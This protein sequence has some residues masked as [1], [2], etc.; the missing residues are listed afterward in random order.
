MKTIIM[1]KLDLAMD[2]GTIVE[3]FKREGEEVKEGERVVSIMTQKVTYEI[4]SPA[5]GTLYKVFASANEDVPVGKPIA[6]IME[7]GD[8]VADV[9]RYIRE[10]MAEKAASKVEIKEKEEITVEVKEELREEIERIKISPIARKLAEE[11]GIDITKIK[12][13]G[14]GG[15]IT[16]EDVLKAIEEFKARKEKE[17]IMPLTGIRKIIA[18]R[19]V[20][21]HKTIP[22]VTYS[23]EV[24]ATQMIAVRDAF[25]KEKNIDLSYNTLITR[26]VVKAIIDYPIFNSTIEGENIRIIDDINI[27]IAVATDYG[28]VVP[29]IHNADK[30]DIMELNAIVRDLVE[31]ARQNKLTIEDVSNGTFI[32]TN[33]GMFGVDVFT[34]IIF[35]GQVAILGV[36]RIVEKPVVS[37]GQI[38]IKPFMTLSLTA[39]HRVIDGAL[40]AKFLRKIKEN[41]EN[42][43]LII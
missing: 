21:S 9:E 41:L 34:P 42:I 6:V 19:M 20:L 22:P 25:K 31:R 38:V 24:D 5:N 43:H 4:T 11:H 37:S 30:K 3:W 23:M 14:P 16:K 15:R 18:E 32:I 2:S 29:V 13:T 35:P 27:G 17:K 40:A 1:P 10:V 28:L 39:D 36:G 8:N 12:G 33:L 7:P 26:A